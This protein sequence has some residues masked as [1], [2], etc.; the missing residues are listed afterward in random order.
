M[1]QFISITIF[2]SV[3]GGGSVVADAAKPNIVYLLAD[4]LGWGDISVNGGRIPTPHID[5]LFAQGVR[6]DNFMGWSVCSPTR[7]MLL[8][9]RHPFR[10]GTG[11]EVGGELAKE[12]T[13]IAE[14]FKASGYRTGVLGACTF[15][16]RSIRD[17]WCRRLRREADGRGSLRRGGLR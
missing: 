17:D 7:A 9:G 3:L 11:P 8:T 13:T 14:G 1:K 4:D 6:L 5:R 2:L 10:V 12:E 15:M 16:R